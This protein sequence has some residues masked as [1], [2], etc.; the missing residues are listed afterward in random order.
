M[1]RASS[2]VR[3]P[4]VRPE[5]VVDRIVLDHDA[6]HRRRIALTGTGGIDVLLDLDKA[7]VLKAGDALKLAD[8]RLVLVEA[9]PE[10]LLEIRTENRLRLM[11][12]AW[13][14]GNRHTPAELTEEAIYIAYDHVLEEMVRGLGATT[15]IVERP[16]EPEGGAYDGH[17]H[18]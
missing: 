14:I 12:L 1:L 13:H 5:R 4:A 7:T 9:A 6:R 8:G 10:K 17:A 15:A 16:F 2:I 18:G 3:K 11:R